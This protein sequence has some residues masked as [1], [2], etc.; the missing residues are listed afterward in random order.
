MCIFEGFQDFQYTTPL[1]T[2]QII[3]TYELPN[4]NHAKISSINRTNRNDI[5]HVHKKKRQLFR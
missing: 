5:E 2:Y 3:P 1:C 4:K